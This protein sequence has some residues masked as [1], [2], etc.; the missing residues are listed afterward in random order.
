MLSLREEGARSRGTSQEQMALE[1]S[2]QFEHAGNCK[3][4]LWLKENWAYEM[5]Y[6]KPKW[7]DSQ[8]IQYNWK[9][10]RKVKQ[11]LT[12]WNLITW[13]IWGFHAGYWRMPSSGMWRRVGL[14]SLDLSSL[15]RI[16]PIH[17]TPYYSYMYFNVI[18]S[19]FFRS[20]VPSIIL[21]GK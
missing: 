3:G 12:V 14:P 1:Q 6:R 5:K 7:L 15:N 20:R 18:R 13:R 9:M 8:R 11:F 10:F 4:K 17:S 16:Q 21:L 2:F 19:G